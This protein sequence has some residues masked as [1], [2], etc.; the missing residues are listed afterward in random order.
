MK[1]I[2]SGLMLLALGFVMA[3]CVNENGKVN[4]EI[5][6]KSYNVTIDVAEFEDLVVAAIEKVERG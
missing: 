2:F 4:N 5:Y 6:N 1:K 3:G